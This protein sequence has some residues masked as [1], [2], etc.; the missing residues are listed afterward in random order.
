MYPGLCL[1]M[2]SLYRD[3]EGN[4]IF[5]YHAEEDVIRMSTIFVNESHCKGCK[6][7]RKKVVELERVI[8]AS[9]VN[10]FISS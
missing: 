6:N 5:S 2:I 8:N 7:L 1:Q 9:K 4:H 10:S 3:P